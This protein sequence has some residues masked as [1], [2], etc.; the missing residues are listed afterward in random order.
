MRKYIEK[1]IYLKPGE[2]IEIKNHPGIFGWWVVKGRGKFLDVDFGNE[3]EIFPDDKHADDLNSPP[4][5]RLEIKGSNFI[6]SADEDNI[7]NLIIIF[8][9][10][11]I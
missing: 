2:K 4:L 6:F 10:Y 8:F 9:T 5:N 7:E 11:K 3:Y 1:I